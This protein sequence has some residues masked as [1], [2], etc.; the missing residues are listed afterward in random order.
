M[1]NNALKLLLPDLQRR[2]LNQDVLEN[3]FGVIRAKGG[4]QDHTNALEFKY[5][6]RS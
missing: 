5:R 3:F 2:R 4:L 1:S 6:L